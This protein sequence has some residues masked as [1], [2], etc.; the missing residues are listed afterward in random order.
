MKIFVRIFYIVMVFL[1]ANLVILS[2]YFGFGPLSLIPIVFYIVALFS[3][4][5]YP[6]K[7]LK[8]R[9]RICAEGA[10]QLVVF[11][12]SSALCVVFVAGMAPHIGEQRIFSFTLSILVTILA[13]S[14]LFWNGMIRIYLTSAQLG[15]KQRILGLLFGWIPIANIIMLFRLVRTAMEEAV[16][17]NDKLVTNS[18]RKEDEICKTRY[19]LLMVH[20]VFFRD[21]KYFN[22][23]GRAADELI[24]HG[25]EI[26]YGNHPS[27]ASVSDCGRALA[28]KIKDIVNETGCEKVNIIAHSKGGLDARAAISLYEAGDR[29]AS[30][31]TVCT[32]HRG[33][34]FAE[35]LL[36]KLSPRTK[37][38]VASRYNTTLARLGDA[39][40]DFLAA[41]TDLT[42]RACA[43]FNAIAPDD[44]RVFYQSVG[45]KMR[46]ASSGRFPLNHSYR[47]VRNHDGDNDGLVSMS[48]AMWGE[49][50]IPLVPKGRRGIS[51]GDVID[52]TRE[53]IEGFDVREFYVGL[54][55]DL[56]NRGL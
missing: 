43:A 12:A 20:G 53:N 42:S 39:K 7:M 6:R 9:L 40:P 38:A 10:E 4:A 19:P 22:Y 15:L 32:P 11:I 44:P 23:W 3:P 8:R 30:L 2:D 56:K 37:E 18:L 51:H 52:L 36:E 35:N 41:V 49:R 25:A 5:K 48:S 46:H 54:V 26:H 17:E 13:E 29:V 55:S 24:Q 16:F 1:A 50:F 14:V 27:A 21:M 47:M 33:C 34:N 28:D 45:A 31:T